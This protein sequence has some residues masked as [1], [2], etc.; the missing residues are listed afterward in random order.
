[1]DTLITA[2]GNEARLYGELLVL[3]SQ[4]RDALVALK[5]ADVDRIVAQEEA[6]LSSLGE[7]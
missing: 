3:L 7:A 4:K 6:L 2:L 1:M 5:T